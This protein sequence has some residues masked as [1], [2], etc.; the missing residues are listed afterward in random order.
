MSDLEKAINAKGPLVGQRFLDEDIEELHAGE[1]EFRECRF[2]HCRLD[3]A[4]F[5]ACRFISC[6]F[7]HC[8]FKEAV[9]ESC[10]FAEGEAATEWRYCDI[11]KAEFR[12]S[13]LSLNRMIGCEGYLASFSECAAPG[14]RLD[15]N[16]QRRV[17]TQ[18]I[19][20][21]LNFVK[22]KLQYA[23]FAPSDLRESTFESC[24]LR[25]C[26]FSGSNLA[27]ASFRG[28]SLNNA[29]F[30]GATLDHADLSHA[31]F[32]MLDFPAMASYHAATVTPDQHEA[33][34]TSFGL[35]TAS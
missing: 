2:V 4:V 12:K 20:G 5:N 6:A 29:D 9:F 1:V 11:S 19:A 27:N 21:G 16:A 35:L 14:I 32:D 31:S 30:S 3:F 26:S 25:D 28:S 15:I 13:N 17:R 7:D 10:H 8:S 33:I 18:V 23:E 34:A 22:C 24:D